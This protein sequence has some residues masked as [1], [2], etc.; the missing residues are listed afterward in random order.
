MT[1][2]NETRLEDMPEHQVL[3]AEWKAAGGSHHGPNVETVTMPLVDYIKFRAAL[4]PY[5]MTRLPLT[6]ESERND[7][8][9]VFMAR[10]LSEMADLVSRH[11][12]EVFD[13]DRESLSILLHRASALM[14]TQS[15]RIEDRAAGDVE[16]RVAFDP[17]P[18]TKLAAFEAWFVK[19]YPGP[20]TIISDPKWHAPRIFRAAQ[21]ALA[22]A[23]PSAEPVTEPMSETDRIEFALRDAGFDYERAY[24]IAHAAPSAAVG[25]VYTMEALV[26]GGEVRCHVSLNRPLPAGT[27]LY[28]TP[29]QARPDG[30]AGTQD[31]EAIRR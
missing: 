1:T 12:G 6:N 16:G 26:P 24:A 5:L 8:A 21:A 25:E 14:R 30:G 28:T 18:S 31:R 20:D 27:K 19:N 3:L 17:H 15:P 2:K 22:S 23:T 11:T 9:R 7:A 10:D 4:S 29:R 13:R